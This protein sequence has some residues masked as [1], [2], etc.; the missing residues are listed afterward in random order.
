MHRS[1]NSVLPTNNVRFTS[2]RLFVATLIAALSLSGLVDI[3][4]RYTFY[5]YIAAGVFSKCILNK[6]DCCM[7]PVVYTRVA[8]LQA[9]IR[10]KAS[11]VRDS[12]G[13]PKMMEVGQYECSHCGTDLNVMLPSRL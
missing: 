7:D 3:M 9:W 11:G 10:E 8:T 1:L 2:N 6:Q 5:R 12:K 4:C 13:C